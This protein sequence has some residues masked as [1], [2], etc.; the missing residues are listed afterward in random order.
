MIKSV[1]NTGKEL[2][3]KRIQLI[4]F[5]LAVFIII[6]HNSSVYNYNSD[7]VLKLY[8]SFKYSITEIAVPLFFIISGFNFFN[9]FSIDIYKRKFK[10]RIKSLLIPY[11]IWNVLFCIFNIII[12]QDF[13]SQ[14]FIGRSKFEVT[15]LN[16]VLGCLYHM[17][18]NSQFWFVFTLMV[19][20]LI[21]PVFYYILK[22][23]YVGC[24]SLIALYVAL[25]FFH[26]KLPSYFF[27]RTDA[28]LY[29]F[30]G[31]YLG[32]HCSSHFTSINMLNINSKDLCSSS[33]NSNCK[34][35]LTIVTFAL[36]LLLSMIL[37]IPEL[38]DGIR[39]IVILIVSYS[40][41]NVSY[42]CK[43]INIKWLPQGGTIFLMYAAHGIIQ[44]I[45]V[46]ILYLLL[47]KYDFISVINFVLAVGITV[48]L[49]CLIRLVT[50]RYLPFVDKLITGWRR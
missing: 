9:G 32:L 8:D 19:C 14:Y 27:Y 6:R 20:V 47:P 16:V 42:L 21:N 26:F 33:N 44:P 17:G 46:K 22:N 30:I 36:M 41:W 1:I 2:Y 43:F 18:C 40:F 4:S 5:V 45:I 31:A 48:A 23:K 15:P 35:I 13:F 12:S 38:H 28:F 50:K 10:S 37:L 29:Y 25:V 24:V 3:W 39:V 49:C 11:W 7:L 34:D